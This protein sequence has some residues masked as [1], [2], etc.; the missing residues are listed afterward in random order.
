LLLASYWSIVWLTF[1]HWR[2]RRYVPLKCPLNLIWLNGFMSQKAE[3]FVYTAARTSSP[4][5]I[6]ISS[7]IHVKN[8]GNL[9][10]NVSFHCSPLWI[11]FLH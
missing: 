4:A 1:Q 11:E 5:N 7:I 6:S 2:C 10:W 3:F 9:R 8:K